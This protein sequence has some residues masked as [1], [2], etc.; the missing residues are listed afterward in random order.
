MRNP[1]ESEAKRPAV[2]V[3]RHP[4]TGELVVIKRGESGYRPVANPA[5]ISLEKLNVALGVDEVEMDAMLAGSMFGWDC[6][7]ANPPRDSKAE[8]N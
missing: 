3:A 4:A 1:I 6:P 7:A 5:N 2:C 8:N